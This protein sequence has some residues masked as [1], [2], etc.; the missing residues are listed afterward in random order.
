MIQHPAIVTALADQCRRAL[1]AE[2][3][4][5]RMARAT[6]DGSATWSAP[7]FRPRRHP[8][9]PPTRRRLVGLCTARASRGPGHAGMH[10]LVV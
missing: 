8:H 1:V 5:A 6:R 9:I 4:T 2:A 7:W 3:E 10:A